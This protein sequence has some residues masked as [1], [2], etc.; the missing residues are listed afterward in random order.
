MKSGSS[1]FLL[2]DLLTICYPHCLGQA[3]DSSLAY[4]P[5]AAGNQ[6]EYSVY[7]ANPSAYVVYTITIEGDTLMA[8]G[9]VYKKMTH[10]QPSNGYHSTGFVR[11][12]SS[13]AKLYAYN[14][15]ITPSEF[16][17]DSL[18]IGLYDFS[19]LYGYL[20][21][22]DTTSVFGAPVLTRN[23]IAYDGSAYKV[24]YGFGYVSGSSPGPHSIPTLTNLIYAKING[25]EYGS[26]V[27]S[28]SP[29][30]AEVPRIELLQNY[31]NPFNPSTT[32]RFN[33]VK[34]GSVTL[35][36]FDLLGRELV[37]LLSGNQLPGQ[38]EVVFDAKGATSG[39]YF[40]RLQTKEFSI[41]KAMNLAK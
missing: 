12:D 8:N 1:L 17:Y 24:A 13:E 22:I 35:K 4:F 3:V 19:H 40:Y 27:G 15:S 2:F 41:S 29:S 25:H 5:F 6:W 10:D 31:P 34:S 37:T 32:I 20:I 33:L 9:K 16:L 23:F 26:L 28:V 21:K 14:S 7:A 38:H 30:S 18:R 39:V 11:M 36:V